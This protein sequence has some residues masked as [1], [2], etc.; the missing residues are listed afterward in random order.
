MSEVSE[1]CPKLSRKENKGKGEN[2]LPLHDVQGGRECEGK[3]FRTYLRSK[4]CKTVR[5]GKK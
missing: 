4:T 5:A 2:A 3:T 1:E